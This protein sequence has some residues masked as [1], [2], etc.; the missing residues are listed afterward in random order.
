[1]RKRVNQDE[2]GR[3][4]GNGKGILGGGRPAAAPLIKGCF[5]AGAW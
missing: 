5:N 1:M 2:K 3:P 4:F